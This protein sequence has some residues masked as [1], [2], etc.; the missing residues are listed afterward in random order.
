MA[1]ADVF[2]VKIY[3]QFVD[4]GYQR[5]VKMRDRWATIPIKSGASQ[6]PI[7]N[8]RI[9]SLQ[10]QQILAKHIT[11]RYKSARYWDERGSTVLD[12]VTSIH[13]DKLWVLNYEL[14]LGVRDIL[15]ITTPLSIAV[16]AVGRKSVGL[17]S[18]LHRYP[19]PLTYISGNGARVYM[20][21]C[22][23]FTDAGITVEFS[24]HYAV[25]SD[26]ILSVLFDYEDPMK[27]VLAESAADVPTFMNLKEPTV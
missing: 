10:A 17:I 9:D 5:R 24:K 21:D 26:S 23:E 6:Q 7:Y 20:G 8:A 13:T 12:L 22:K 15:G 14:I 3:D 2:D 11:D 18:V 25:T 19:G 4:R 16:P 1:K 27:V